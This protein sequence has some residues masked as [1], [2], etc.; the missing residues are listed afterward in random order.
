MSEML[1]GTC[2]NVT[3]S[4]HDVYHLQVM[5][6]KEQFIAGAIIPSFVHVRCAERLGI[7]LHLMF[8]FPYT[9]MRTFP[10]SLTNIKKKNVYP[11]YTNFMSCLLG[12]DDLA[13]VILLTP[14]IGEESEARACISYFYFFIFY[15]I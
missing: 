4:K 3:D 10:H 13:R 7:L 11:G 15:F 9:P 5:G 6:R 1:E 14:I 2:I 12:G 8:S